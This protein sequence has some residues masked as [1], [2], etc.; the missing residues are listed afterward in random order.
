V[1]GEASNGGLTVPQ[2]ANLL[3]VPEAQ[4]W[5]LLREGRLER[6]PGV[7]GRIRISMRSIEEHLA[8]RQ[9]RPTTIVGLLQ[10]A[11][12]LVAAVLVLVTGLAAMA[13]LNTDVLNNHSVLRW[14]AQVGLVDLSWRGPPPSPDNVWSVVTI[15]FTNDGPRP[16]A[17]KASVTTNGYGQCPAA[18]AISLAGTQIDWGPNPMIPQGAY[19]PEVQDIVVKNAPYGADGSIEVV[20][21]SCTWSKSYA[22]VHRYAERL[23][24]VEIPASSPIYSD[25]LN[26]TPQSIARLADDGRCVMD[27]LTAATG[28]IGQDVPFGSLEPALRETTPCIKVSGENIDSQGLWCFTSGS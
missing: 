8:K 19:I 10:R 6:Q 4:V 16:A 26:P 12:G 1:S 21:A 11:W 28:P 13:I 14:S 22:A 20:F 27:V 7:T 9:S 17:F 2:T 25:C 3:G 23:D 24:H 18:T 15:K 5:A